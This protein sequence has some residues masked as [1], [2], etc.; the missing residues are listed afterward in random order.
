MRPISKDTII[1]KLYLEILTKFILEFIFKYLENFLDVYTAYTLQLIERIKNEINIAKS[2][3][4]TF[5]KIIHILTVNEN[6]SELIQKYMQS[7]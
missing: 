4:N 6:T 1:Q 7:K 2:V 3:R 5:F